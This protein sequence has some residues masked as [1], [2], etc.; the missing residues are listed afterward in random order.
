MPRHPFFDVKPLRGIDFILREFSHS[1]RKFLIETM[2]AGWPS[3]TTTYDGLLDIF[4]SQRRQ[5]YWSPCVC[6]RTSI[7]ATSRY[8]NKTAIPPESRR[9]LLRTSH[10]PQVWLTRETVTY[11]MGVAVG[12]YDN[13]GYPDLF[14]T[15]YGK[16]ILLS[17]QQW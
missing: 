13:D 1:Q 3:S 12:D 9:E 10:A 14:V 4:S 11:G 7:V 8:W 16:N 5:D 2:P 15:S 17:C 6:L